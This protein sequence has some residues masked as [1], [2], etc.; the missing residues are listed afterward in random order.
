MTTFLGH[1][2]MSL[3]AAVLLPRRSDFF[4]TQNLPKPE[5]NMSSQGSRGC[6]MNSSNISTVSNRLFTGVPVLLYH[7]VDNIG[8]GEGAGF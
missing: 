7:G 5:I 3:P 1:I 2:I 8:F 6:L 4:L